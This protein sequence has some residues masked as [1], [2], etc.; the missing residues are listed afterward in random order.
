MISEAREQ[1]ATWGS[2]S[3]LP[4]CAR[5]PSDWAG[6][7]NRVGLRQPSVTVHWGL[8]QALGTEA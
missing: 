7:Q 5:P 2:A 4:Q 8:G 1:Q 3:N 6:A